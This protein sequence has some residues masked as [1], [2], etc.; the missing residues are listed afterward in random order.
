MTEHKYRNNRKYWD[1][2]ALANSVAPDQTPHNAAS[3]QGLHRLP[4]IQ[5]FLDISGFRLS[6]LSFS[7]FISKIHNLVQLIIT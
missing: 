3:D 6:L 2:R 5:M 7:L 4:L 1:R